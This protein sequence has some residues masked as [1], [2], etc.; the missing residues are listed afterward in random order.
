MAKIAVDLDMALIRRRE[1]GEPSGTTP[2]RLAAGAGWEAADVL[3][4]HGPGDAPF[5][6]RHAR[7]VIALVV[8]GAFEYRTSTGRGLMTPGSLML[9]NA[10]DCFECGHRH[11]EGDRCIA[12]RFTPEFFERVAADAGVRTQGARFRL[13][14]VAPSRMFAPFV[15]SA[16]ARVARGSTQ[17]WDT[18]AL[19]LAAHMLRQASGLPAHDTRAIP[20]AMLARVVDVLR[21]IDDAPDAALD[22]ERL[23]RLAGL[24]P[25][26][27]LRTFERA[28]GTTPHQYIVR[29]RLRAA[30]QRLVEHPTKII[31]VAL[32]SG[33]DD[34][35]NFNRAF[36]AEFGT[37]P[38]AYRARLLS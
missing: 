14:R 7:V 4:T 3:C 32:E 18:F 2:R 30:A 31:D 29:A 16:C 1:E 22:L 37:S 21:V 33:F 25:Y 12:L 27:F 13:A 8:A 23:A 9:G 17:G 10:H 6:E 35:S 28:T 19:A 15:A 20:A 5:E 36:R 11:R 34:V 24:S 38:R 26:H